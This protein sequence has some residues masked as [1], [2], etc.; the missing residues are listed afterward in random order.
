MAS[1][2]GNG[3]MSHLISFG[4][5]IDICKTGEKKKKKK[6]NTAEF[7]FKT[8]IKMINDLVDEI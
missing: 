6:N 4:C 8:I 1:P 7:L 3:S 2:N 5:G